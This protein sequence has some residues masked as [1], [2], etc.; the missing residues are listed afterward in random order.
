MSTIIPGLQ[1]ADATDTIAHVI[2]VAL[3]PV[4]LLSGIAALMN[5]FNTRLSR[6][7]DQRSA[8]EKEAQEATEP[9]R[10]GQLNAHLLKLRRRTFVLDASIMFAA[11]GGAATCAAALVLF[12]GSLREDSIAS[13][14]FV[15]FGAALGC[16][17][18]ALT[19]FLIDT[20]LAWH[21]M[22]RRHHTPN[23]PPLP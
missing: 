15:M 7:S 2:Q 19:A 16:T 3:T 23:N 18:C 22:H 11:V 17:V 12:L 5:V 20:V 6:V 14:L 10:Q 9:E 13:W 4:F 21:W 1:P 8:T